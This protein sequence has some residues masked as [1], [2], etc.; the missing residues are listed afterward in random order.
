VKTTKLIVA[1][2]R[3]LFVL[4]EIHYTLWDNMAEI[5]NFGRRSY[6]RGGHFFN[7]STSMDNFIY[8]VL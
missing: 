3:S 4:Y 6:I 1:D 7:H 8:P 2:K 5:Q